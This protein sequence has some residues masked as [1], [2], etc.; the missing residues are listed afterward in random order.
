[1]NTVRSRKESRGMKR[2]RNR[3]LKRW[4]GRLCVMALV[5]AMTFCMMPGAGLFSGP[6]AAYAAEGELS[7]EVDASDLTMG[8]DYTLTGD[9]VINV[10]ADQIIGSLNIGNYNLSVEGDDENILSV[11]GGITGNSGS[12][13]L[14]GGSLDV[15][16][17]AGTANWPAAIKIPVGSVKISGG[18]LF[19]NFNSDSPSAYESYGIDA[20]SFEMTGGTATITCT[21]ASHG[22]ACGISTNDFKMSG[23]SL[24]AAG[25]TEVSYEVGSG[26]K[27]KG[28]T[29]DANFKM[30]G[31]GL[32]AEGYGS[33]G[34][35]IY[36]TADKSKN[37][38]DIKGGT[39]VAKGDSC[40][41]ASWVFCYIS[42][43]AEVEA[44]GNV[45]GIAVQG[46][47]LG[48]DGA[49]TK[50][51]AKATSGSA[52][53][54]TRGG[55]IQFSTGVSILEPAGGSVKSTGDGQSVFDASDNI[56]KK[57]VTYCD[58]IPTDLALSYD[59][60]KAFPTTRLTG[61][62]VSMYFLRSVTSN[63]EYGD[64]SGGWYVYS[65]NPNKTDKT[66]NKYT[67]LVRKDGDHFV[68]LHES[69]E[70]LN[71]TDEYYF[72][73]N[74]ENKG[75][76]FD[77]QATY[78]ATVNGQ[79]ADAVVQPNGDSGEMFVYKRA[80]LD[81]TSDVIWSLTVSPKYS[82]VVPG[83]SRH[84]TAEAFAATDDSVSWSLSDTYRPGTYVTS[85]GVLHVA[86]DEP[87]YTH[88]GVRATSVVDPSVYASADVQVVENA[89]S[90]DSV[91]LHSEKTEICR[92]S[93]ATVSAE[94]EGDDIDDL[95]W[96]LIGS[97]GSSYFDGGGNL[98]R[99]LSVGAEETSGELT[100]RATSVADPTKYGEWKFTITDKEVIT[101]PINITYDESAVVL[102]GSKTG[103]Q[104]TQDFRGAITS[105]LS[106]KDASDGWY[107][108]TS[109]DN[110]WTS[111]IYKNEAGIF[112]QDALYKSEEPLTAD[113][114]YYLW[115]NIEDRE[116]T[117]YFDDGSDLADLNITVNGHRVN[118]DTVV[119]EWG[120]R[121]EV[122]VRVYFEGQTPESP[123]ERIYGSN[124]YQT[125]FEAADR[126]K[127]ELGVEKF[128]NIVVASGLDFPDA[129][130]GA[131]LAEVKNAP[132]L[133]TN[134][135]T[136]PSVAEY[137]KDN[138]VSDGTVFIL[139]GS[140]A[141]PEAMEDALSAQGIANVERLAGS[142]R[143]LTNIKILEEAGV[144]GQDILICAGS[145][146][147]DSLPASAVGKPVFLVSKS[148]TPDQ[149]DYLESVKG[150]ISGN[151]YAI[152]GTGVVSDAVFD[153][154][155]EYGSG[156]FKRV[157]GSN[158]YKTSVAIAEEFFTPEIKS[159]VLAYA[160]N[161][162]DGLAGGPIAYATG[163][164]LL[165]VTDSAYG[166]A[167]DYLTGTNAVKVKVMGGTALISDETAIKA[168]N[169]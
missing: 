54:T 150:S 94:V 80:Y 39:V 157:A 11:W 73:F 67:C 145:G 27:P 110:R 16:A 95:T 36:W 23:G 132:I 140:G 151:F 122:Y 166:D 44:T 48:V 103:K 40:G 52:I 2:N 119:A 136:A 26:I 29:S 8:A 139:G 128:E 6:A 33:E 99:Y 169:L 160:M 32:R 74:I 148:L 5:I 100:V 161:Y 61:R 146:Y 12:L 86:S 1:M 34:Y 45:N 71:T 70:P 31:G 98:Y 15:D 106:D 14:N 156:T 78:T 62:E 159:V 37:E 164:P 126:L 76:C 72:C 56:A 109:D 81:E 63:P 75:R 130:A 165:L 65:A 101:G 153:E 68:P 46:S 116:D 134:S 123:L 96:E 142:N 47:D 19:I 108:F 102:N 50:V 43:G 66:T 112:V 121:I 162:P 60:S 57:V 113:R 104:V 9:T 24:G 55:E 118:G 25:E 88:I 97:D 38:M 135:A 115:F 41:I 87:L 105:P 64:T 42:G 131:Y 143:Y 82:K 4:P 10:D 77:T 167:K 84:L 152:G 49:R 117:H 141:V 18:G 69:D 163:S 13:N 30:T 89:P 3:L 111:L 7:G 155:H 20:G 83:G 90:I 92:G 22:S 149:K 107:V 114:E 58:V 35:G 138:M 53:S 137:V 21:A 85:D 168:L 124:R 154:F 144:S 59:T 17:S 79:P 129:L 147:A 133:L 158:R 28:A 125:A 127:A 93:S 120:G 51:T 91:T